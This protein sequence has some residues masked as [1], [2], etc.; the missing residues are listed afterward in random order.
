MR[1]E[2]VL[3][4]GT[5]SSNGETTLNYTVPTGAI[6]NVNLILTNTTS[7]IQKVDIIISTNLGDLLLSSGNIAGGNGKTLY[8]DT[9][10]LAKLNAGDKIKINKYTTDTINYYLSGTEVS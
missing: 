10:K 5:I 4:R 9:L 1:T 6:A 8:I 2:K 3:D 7:N